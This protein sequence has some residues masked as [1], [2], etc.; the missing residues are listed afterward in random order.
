M[1]SD[2]PVLRP[3]TPLLDAIAQGAAL[4]ELTQ[5]QLRQ[6]TGELRSYLLY[7]V[8][9]SGGHQRARRAEDGLGGEVRICVQGAQKV[10]VGGDSLQQI[11]YAREV[12]V[13]LCPSIIL[14]IDPRIF[15]NPHESFLIRENS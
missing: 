2:I 10:R 15:T 11:R 1:L 14:Q 7:S 4:R 12:H 3:A 8:G 13:D 6:L 5:A 9:Q